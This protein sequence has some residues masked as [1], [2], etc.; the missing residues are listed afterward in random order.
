MKFGCCINMLANESDKI[1]LLHIKAL[2]ELGFDYVELPLAEISTLSTHELAALQE[3]LNSAGLSCESC[4]NFFPPTIRLTGD[5]VDVIA[6]KAYATRAMDMAQRLGVKTLV[7]GSGGAKNV[8]GGF[9]YD[10][11]F[12]QIIELLKY[13]ATEAQVREITICI[14]P[15][16][17]AECNI[18]NT[19]EEGCRLAQAVN[20]PNIKVLVDLY[21]LAEEHE[22][23]SNIITYGADYLRHVHIA[24]PDARSFPLEAEETADLF[25]SFFSALAAVG[26]DGT[27]SCEAYTKN[28][29]GDAPRALKYLKEL[30][31]DALAHQNRVVRNERK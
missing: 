17:K 8:P 13:L 3:E 29:Q 6:V 11:A 21:H 27:I 9:P 7:F 1:G 28:L 16:R 2:K 20:S 24:A 23:V 10:A 12:A 22:S 18:I 31:K 4:N 5:K 30:S 26:Y 15:L 25:K 19:F 14:E